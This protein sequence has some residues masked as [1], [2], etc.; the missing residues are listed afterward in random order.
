[1]I[2]S[3]DIWRRCSMA[4]CRYRTRLSV[5]QDSFD[6]LYLKSSI[7]IYV[8]ASHLLS[9]GIQ[10]GAKVRITLLSD[11]KT[12]PSLKNI[13]IAQ[14]IHLS[15]ILQQDPPSSNSGKRPDWLTLLVREVL[16]MDSVIVS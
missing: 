9:A 14:Y 3:K 15:E 11:K 13:K 1:M 6:V 7:G 8:S 5:C 12:S 4:I 10:G 2:Y 16:G